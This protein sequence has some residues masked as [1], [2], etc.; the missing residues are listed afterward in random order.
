M[1]KRIQKVVAGA[2]V[3]SAVVMGVPAG[4][5]QAASVDFDKVE[6]HPVGS[7]ATG[8]ASANINISSKGLVKS[9]V[10]VYGKGGTSKIVVKISLQRYG[11]ESK[12]WSNVKTWDVTSQTAMVSC[13]KKYDL[14]KKGTYRCK[15]TGTIT[16][17]G[18][19]ETVTATSNHAKY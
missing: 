4:A 17:N 6:I 10:T 14:S 13:T 1:F 5:V 9:D 15:V 16:C 7:A 18:K 11:K 12:K 3:L 19:N 8:I 2:V